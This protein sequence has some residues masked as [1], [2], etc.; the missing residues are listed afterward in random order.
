M[1]PTPYKNIELCRATLSFCRRIRAQY[2]TLWAKIQDEAR[3]EAAA[4]QEAADGDA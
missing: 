1:D 2:P 3:R 4:K